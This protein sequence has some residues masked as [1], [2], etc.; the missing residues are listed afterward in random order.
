L[1]KGKRGQYFTP[2]PLVDLLL[3]RVALAPGERVLDPTCGSGGFLVRAAQRGA[4]VVGVE[5][6]P[7]L[8]DLARLNLELAGC[9]GEV[10]AGDAF[11]TDF[12]SARAAPREIDPVDVVVA[13]PPFSVA[14]R[15]PAVLD[16]Y[17]LARGRPQ[18]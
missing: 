11:A 7:L 14:I 15:D 18:V 12:S 5:L 9:A 4:R 1:F 17:A 2:R 6:D 10:I 16:R 8:A 13:N 3:D